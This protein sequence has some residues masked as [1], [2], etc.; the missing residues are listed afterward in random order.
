M[1]T[2]RTPQIS[3]YGNLG[4]DPETR[5]LAG[6]I[7]TQEI[8][9]PII[10]DVVVREYTTPSR[11]IRIASLAVSARDEAGREITRWHRLV[12]FQDQLLS[13]RKGDRIK[14]RGYFRDRQYV[15]DGE[16][17]TIRELI[18]TGAELVR[19]KVRQEAA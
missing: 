19:L 15:K 8:Y 6:N 5:T 3:F 13:Y 14:V 9:D 18:V 12:D 1:T 16:T 4:G 11:Q 10:D 7:R 17:K 2:Q